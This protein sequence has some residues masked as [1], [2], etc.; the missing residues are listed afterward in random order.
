[1]TDPI[2]NITIPTFNRL[3]YTKRTIHSLKKNTQTPHQLI[4]VDN[5]STDGTREFLIGL[6]KGGLIDHLVLFD[7]NMGVSCAANVGF[8]TFGEMPLYM[9]LDNDMEITRR[10]WLRPILSIWHQ[11]QEVSILGPKLPDSRHPFETVTLPNG[12]RLLRALSN[13]S[14]AALIISKDVFDKVGY[15]CE[16]YGLYGE[17]DADYSHRCKMA[18]YLLSAF[19]AEGTV[20]HLGEWKSGQKDYV[21]FK[22]FQRDKNT[23]SDKGMGFFQL[24]CYLYNHN[25][26]PVHADRKF[27]PFRRDEYT[28]ETRLDKQGIARS[29]FIYSCKKFIDS[30]P[31][32]VWDA[33]MN[34]PE[35]VGIVRDM[36]NK[37]FAADDLRPQT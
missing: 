21:T 19:E 30:F 36:K 12:S 28:W 13:L 33:I 9:K 34:R 15:F 37:I 6:H 3:E 32:P 10:D 8:A 17:E 31:E 24:H 25:L 4:V 14:G 35:T 18:G 2:I 23:T 22:Q 7:R 11:N 1:M 16:D 20:T 5:G 29:R 26:L 27:I